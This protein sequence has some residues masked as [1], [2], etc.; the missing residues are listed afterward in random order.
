MQF[1]FRPYTLEL[2]HP[3]GVA[4]NSRTGSPSVCAIPVAVMTAKLAI[5]HGAKRFQTLA[6][7]SSARCH[8]KARSAIITPDPTA[9]PAVNKCVACS[10]RISQSVEVLSDHRS[11]HDRDAGRRLIEPFGERA[12]AAPDANRSDG[13]AS[14]CPAW[15]LHARTF[16]GRN[17]EPTWN[18]Q[19]LL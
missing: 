9:T 10:S 14:R 1:R 6:N 12:H 13:R 4:V 5:N 18:V 11:G 15:T 8:P 2:R 7:G 19:T 17:G 3:F 16:H